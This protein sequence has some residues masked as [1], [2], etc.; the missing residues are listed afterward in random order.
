MVVTIGPRIARFVGQDFLRFDS[1]LGQGKTFDFPVEF[2]L[3]ESFARSL[4]QLLHFR[5]LLDLQ[6]HRGSML[7]PVEMEFVLLGYIGHFDCI[8]LRN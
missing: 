1:S 2:P 5:V 7:E 8:G 6:V 4:E 3:K